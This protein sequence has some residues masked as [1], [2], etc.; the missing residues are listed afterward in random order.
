MKR[1]PVVSWHHFDC[2]PGAAIE[3]SSIR[4][5]A[6]TFLTAN[7]KVGVD[8]DPAKGR[9]ILIGDPEHA[10]FDGTVFNTSR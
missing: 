8:F 5:F 7:T 3:K 9:M 4:T 6:D 1:F 10:S 2:V